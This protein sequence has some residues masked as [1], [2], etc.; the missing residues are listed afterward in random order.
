MASVCPEAIGAGAGSTPAMAGVMWGVPIPQLPKDSG[1]EG[2]TSWAAPAPDIYVAILGLPRSQSIQ[3]LE[4]IYHF[5][6]KGSLDSTLEKA[7]YL[8]GSGH[9][10]SEW[11][12]QE[13]DGPRSQPEI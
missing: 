6:I 11:P 12:A 1:S 7:E 9:G 13:P 4:Q 5:G 3:R 2:S 10:Q 8:G